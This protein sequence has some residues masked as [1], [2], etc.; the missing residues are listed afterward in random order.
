MEFPDPE[1]GVAIKPKADENMPLTGEGEGH[2]AATAPAK[3]ACGEPATTV[4]MEAEPQALSDVS[5]VS[6]AEEA[7]V[8]V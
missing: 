7:G 6:A 3:S 8:A 1:A 5:N 4:A 2:H